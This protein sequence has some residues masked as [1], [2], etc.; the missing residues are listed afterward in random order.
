M[1]TKIDSGGYVEVYKEYI[2][3]IQRQVM[4]IPLGKY[5]FLEGK[6]SRVCLHIVL[7]MQQ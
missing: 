1:I 2:K 6:E 4:E 5:Q 3:N 7:L